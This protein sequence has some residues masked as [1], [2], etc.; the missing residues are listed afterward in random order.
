LKELIPFT[1]I[2][3]AKPK[4]QVF[5]ENNCENRVYICI[6]YNKNKKPPTQLSEDENKLILRKI[7][8]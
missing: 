6:K 7:E 8:I 1:S 3:K 2:V 5:F 4:S